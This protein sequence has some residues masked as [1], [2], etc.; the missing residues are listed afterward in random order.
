[1]SHILVELTRGCKLHWCAFVGATDGFFYCAHLDLIMTLTVKSHT[2]DR[3]SLFVF[4]KVLCFSSSD[5][6]R[7]PLYLDKVGNLFCEVLKVSVHDCVNAEG[8]SVCCV[9]IILLQKKKMLKTGDCS[10]ARLF[11]DTSGATSFFLNMFIV[12]GTTYLG[13]WF[14]FQSW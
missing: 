5:S 11:F 14:V 2:G 10:T 9:V 4:M 7:I 13:M 12:V 8:T 1:M 6:F 3:Q